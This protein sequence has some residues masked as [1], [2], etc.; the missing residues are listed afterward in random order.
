LQKILRVIIGLFGILF[1]ALGASFLLDPARAAAGL[2]V[3]A[4][5]PLGLATLRGDFFAFFAAGGLLSLVAAI[6]NDARFLTAPLLMIALTLAGRLITV[7]VNGFDAAMAPPMVVE[8]VIVLLLAL[9][10]R[11]LART[12]AG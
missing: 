6:R 9:G 2:G 11:N 10:Y 5:A 8:A 12:Q 7:A 3:G 4:L 1:M